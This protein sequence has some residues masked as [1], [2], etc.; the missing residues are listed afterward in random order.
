MK[1]VL[2]RN[3]LWLILLLLT[4]G[5]QTLKAQPGCPNINVGSDQTLNCTSPSCATLT[6]S[7]LE[8]GASTSYNVSSIPYSP[9]YPYNSG[10][11][12]MANIDDRWSEI[13]NLPFNFCFFGNVY[14]K[15]VV[16]SNGLI[17]F[18]TTVTGDYC[19][20]MYSETCPDPALQTNAI[21]GP[22]HDIDPSK[23]GG[24]LYYGIQGATPCRT[25]VISFYNVAMYSSSCNSLKATHQIV[26][27][28]NTN[29]IEVYMLNKP[30][31]ASW[32]G[33]NAVVGIQNSTG[34]LGYT[35]PSRNTSVWSTTNEAWRF[36]P[37][38][39]PNFSVA[40]FQ[41]STQ[42]ATGL[43]TSVCPTASTTYTGKVT[44]TNCDASQVIV[45]DQVTV[46]VVNNLNITASVVTPS[47]CAGN[48]TNITANG[49]TSY[50]WYPNTNLS[51]TTGST[52]TASPT[53]TTTYSIIGTLGPCTDTI[54]KT[55]TVS[56][57]PVISISN[58]DSVICN[59][60]S[61]LITANGATTYD[62]S[63]STGLSSVSGTS[64]TA[65]PASTTTYTVTGTTSG[66]T[67]TATAT[68]YVGNLP[69][70]TISSNTPICTG[71]TLNLSS[72]GGTSYSW[73]GPNS[74]TSSDQNPSIAS[75]TTAASGT[76]T[77]TVTGTGGCTATS[78][79]TV[80]VNALPTPT[81]GS[82]SPICAGASLNLTSGGGTGY[83]WSGPNSF[84]N[85]TQNPSI[86]TATTS[87]DGIYIVTITGTGGCTATAQTTV[88][89][90]ANPTP[91]AGNSGPI[92]AGSTLDLTSGGGTGYSWSGPNSF[93]N[94]TQNPSI[95]SATTAA[96][97][98]YT[99]TVTGT[100]GCTATAQTTATVNANVTAIAGS[101]SAICAGATLNLTATPNGGTNYSWS[102]PNSYTNTTQNPSITSTTAAHAGTYIVTVTLPGGCTG[103][104]QTT[105]V[106]NALPTPTIGSNS[107]ICA[108]TSLNLTSG[109]GTGYSWSG[110][111]SFANATQNPTITTA[112]TAASGTYTVTVTGTGSCTSTIQT[113]VV[114]NPTPTPTIG[115][116]SPICENTPLN[117]TSGG[118]TGY[119][120]SGPNSFSNATQNPSITG[121]T[122]SAAG[123]YTVTVTGTG[124]CTSTAQ[125][126]VVVNL[127]PTIVI[128]PAAVQI[129][130]GSDTTLTA[131]GATTYTWTPTSGITP[132][133]GATTTASPT[134]TTTYTAHGTANGCTDSTQVVVTVINIPSI[135]ITPAT[136]SICP[137]EQTT[138][139]GSGGISYV[140][141]PTGTPTPG[142]DSIIT[143][144]PTGTTTYTVT[145]TASGCS[146]TA[147]ATVTIKPLPQLSFTPQNPSIC[148]NGS[149]SM[150]ASGADTYQWSPDSTLSANTGASVI[151]S[152]Q[153]SCA[154]T[155]SG[156]LAGCRDS[157]Q[158][159][160]TV[161]PL[162][163]IS[164]LATPANG[165]QPLHTSFSA[166]ST[167]SAQT[168]AWTMENSVT[169]I[170]PTPNVVF[171]DSGLFDVSLTITDINGCTN[172]ITETDFITVYPKPHV[173]FTISPEFG[174]VSKEVIFT[175]SITAPNSQW[176]WSFGDGQ[177]STVQTPSTNH[178]YGTTG[179]M[180]VL[181]TYTNE[182]GCSD[183]ATLPYTVVIRIVI[184]NV[185]TPNNDGAN[186]TFKIEGLDYVEGAV[187]KIYN[188]WGRK[189]YES[190]NY[191]NDWTGE[192][193]AEGVYFYVLT[194]PDFLKSG[195]FN[196]TV[197]LLR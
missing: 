174:Y 17:T 129:C 63:P 48:S 7:V 164:I 99:V 114:V 23:S 13:I 72:G 146:G 173:S 123:T 93:T 47:F 177:S 67:G 97:G 37:S 169:S 155:L 160:F 159:P 89:V 157:I 30:T 109:G 115:S 55:I 75:A 176:S 170:L 135:L 21:F 132:T 76:Y 9:P 53:T 118:G 124:S 39:A 65:S 86:G 19:S 142:T 10:T 22:Y 153:A 150:N 74:Y 92:C 6:A 8:T 187:M 14:K 140:W 182:F 24:A 128:T 105:V 70:P 73:S 56:S 185:F 149:L 161:N 1:Q 5:N 196:G 36:T 137:G 131:S 122:T 108:G 101:N 189:I 59:G 171:L 113:T 90:N 11:Q 192:D 166:T 27:Y 165:C 145:G 44:Y 18:D 194:L 96:T 139:T 100:G 102:G 34:T 25:F 54:T 26:L 117:L 94:A 119:S 31:C 121:T 148:I 163:T 152:P 95:T 125:T 78:Q 130:N 64:V 3:K 156:T 167:P 158:V 61:A 197:S 68:V 98:T 126:S 60:G 112:T 28:E 33:G 183:T 116:N 20:W 193:F 188:R 62:W 162:P 50:S 175:S 71:A 2:L 138:L 107:P 57:G 111:N 32:N 35:A 184:P 40:W 195:P 190:D 49:A 46:N 186:D 178:Y 82:N 181:H 110:P 179:E 51:D 104:A 85:A 15:I 88:V 12:I 79:T 52:V 91:T 151:A 147:T 106:I 136:V 168:Y 84:A 133:T 143:V 191:K 43:T 83:S 69:T 66:C 41:G 87:A 4:L 77:V 144:S 127:K 29:V 16:G 80:V 141:A 134:A 120:W 154:Y 172:S 180:N 45:E 81:I 58:P 103:T 42:I 38:G